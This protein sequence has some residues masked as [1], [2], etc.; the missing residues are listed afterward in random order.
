MVQSDQHPLP[1]SGHRQRLRQRFLVDESETRQDA[2]FLESLLIAKPLPGSSA[3]DIQQE[4]RSKL[5]LIEN[6]RLRDALAILPGLPLDITRRDEMVAYLH[7]HLSLNS[8]ESRRRMA[9][10][11]ARRFDAT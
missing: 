2:L 4:A 6:A 1:Q 10:Y 7:D 9:D 3:A 5:A 8:S 11:L